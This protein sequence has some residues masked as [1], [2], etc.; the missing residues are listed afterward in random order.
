MNAMFDF[1]KM[2]ASAVK[3]DI[4]Q[5]QSHHPQKQG[6]YNSP[7][8]TDQPVGNLPATDTHPAAV[9][10]STEQ[11]KKSHRNVLSLGSSKAVTILPYGWTPLQT[12]Q[13]TR[14]S[15]GRKLNACYQ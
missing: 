4:Q 7:L 3:Y 6:S 10:V 15:L 2:E 9:P 14:G 1:S 11:K 5:Q 13:L 12:E 8:G